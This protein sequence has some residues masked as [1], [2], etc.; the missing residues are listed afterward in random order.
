MFV[1][2]GVSSCEKEVFDGNCITGKN[3]QLITVSVDQ[4]LYW[5][6]ID[7]QLFNKS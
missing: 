3:S 6:F 2:T 1:L 5:K 7:M 4:D